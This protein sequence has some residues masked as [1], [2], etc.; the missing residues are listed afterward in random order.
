MNSFQQPAPAAPA[1]TVSLLQPRGLR[2]VQ[3]AIYAGVTT[4]F[5]RQAVWRGRLK[6]RR[7]GKFVI[8][9]RD[10]LDQFLESQPL[11][12]TSSAEWLAQRHKSA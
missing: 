10:E 3:A 9:L 12:E 6:A 8:I 11:V 7:C 2:I 5:I 1:I 4:W